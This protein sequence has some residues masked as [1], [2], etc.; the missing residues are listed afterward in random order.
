MKTKS[1][2]LATTAIALV[3]GG[4]MILGRDSTPVY[5]TTRPNANST[6]FVNSELQPEMI[7][8]SY[9][10]NRAAANRVIQSYR[11]YAKAST[12]GSLSEK[13]KEESPLQ[14]MKTSRAEAEGWLTTL[15]KARKGHFH[16]IDMDATLI[17]SKYKEAGVVVGKNREARIKAAVKQAHRTNAE[18]MLADLE[19]SKGYYDEFSFPFMERKIRDGFKASAVTVGPKLNQRIK[20]AITHA[21]KANA[22]HMLIELETTGVAYGLGTTDYLEGKIRKAYQKGSVTVDKKLDER[23]TK[24]KKRACRVSAEK[25]LKELEA[26]APSSAP[27]LTELLIPYLARNVREEFKAS[28]IQVTAAGKLPNA[29]E[30]R[31]NAA[32]R[33][34]AERSGVKLERK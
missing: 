13:T 21:Y 6:T 5:T 29:L 20:Q 11:A 16:E 15:E 7:L 30:A 27:D 8:R 9:L 22:D 12:D 10:E 18:S 25:N 2:L 23:I 32:E 31:I 1:K 34:A 33:Q 4:A 14:K 19:Q 24:A 3:L 26:Y 28:D 17:R